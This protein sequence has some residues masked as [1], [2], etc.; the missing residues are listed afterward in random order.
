MSTLKPG[1]HLRPA[2]SQDLPMI[3]QLIWSERL[4]P[5]Q[6][7]WQQFWIIEKSGE[8][9]ACGQLRDFSDAQELGSLVVKKEWRGQGIG[10]YLTQHL[11]QEATQPLYLE[12]LNNS[13]KHF[14]ES[15]GFEVI[16]WQK[17]PQSLKFKFGLGQLARV[18]FR[19]PFY[20]MQYRSNS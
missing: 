17:L 2:T 9:I 7:R 11:I 20:I 8:I 15:C 13:R 10:T 12:C 6:L 16:S 5:T 3:R 14:Y 18:V 4:D 19:L 1:L